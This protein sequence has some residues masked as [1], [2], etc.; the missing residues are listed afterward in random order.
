MGAPVRPQEPGCRPQEPRCRSLPLLGNLVAEWFPRPCAPP[1]CRSP[2]RAASLT[3]AAS[4]QGGDEAPPAIIVRSL[5][6]FV[7]GSETFRTPGKIDL[8]PQCR[9]KTFAFGG[10]V[11]PS[12]CRPPHRLRPRR[13]VSAT[14]HDMDM[15][16]RHH[17]ADRRNVEFIAR[18]DLPERTR[19]AGDFDHEL[20]LIT[21]VEINDLASAGPPRRQQQP[22]IAGV[23][24]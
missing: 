7:A 14:R 15:E 11:G 16:L 10:I 12:R 4:G 2:R 18:R 20:P 21:F 13:I 24:A 9:D 8:A 1:S 23:A 5:A 19:Y 3:L 17:V 22:G 6:S